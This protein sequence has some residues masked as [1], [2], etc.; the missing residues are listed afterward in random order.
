MS[1]DPSVAHAVGALR[2]VRDGDR[3]ELLCLAR[4]S[5][6]REHLLAEGL[7]R[8]MD[9]GRKALADVGQFA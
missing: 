4:K 8:V 3:D 2:D 1:P 9:V 6:V 5:A 7:E